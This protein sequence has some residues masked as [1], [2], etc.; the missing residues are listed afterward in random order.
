MEKLKLEALAEEW[1][2]RFAVKVLRVGGARCPKSPMG[3]GVMR[4]FMTF[5]NAGAERSPL[6]GVSFGQYDSILSLEM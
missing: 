4:A 1:G 5:Y 6:T 2:S 3:I